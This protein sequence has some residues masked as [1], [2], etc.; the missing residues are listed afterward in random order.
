M[1]KFTLTKGSLAASAVAFSAF[2]SLAL[3]TAASAQ[4]V[5]TVQVPPPPVRAERTPAPRRGYVWS[6][7]HYQ[8]VNGQYVWRR[9]YWVKARPGYAYRAPQWR[10]QNNRWV[11]SRPGW[12]RDRDGVPN[13]Y[14]RDRD[15]DGVPNHRDRFPNNPRRY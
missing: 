1:S 14:D 6:P 9:G 13:R 15:G 12:D 5:I 3:P 2:G 7:G 11:Y 10:Q 4:P 8:W